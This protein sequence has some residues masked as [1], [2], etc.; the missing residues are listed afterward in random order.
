MSKDTSTKVG[1]VVLG[2]VGMTYYLHTKDIDQ[3]RAECRVKFSEEQ[4]Q[5]VITN[6]KRSTN[7]M[8]AMPILGE[9]IFGPSSEQ[10]EQIQNRIA[11][12]CLT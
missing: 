8:S 7:F 2:I 11:K 10:Q 3:A 12:R 5:C 6:I 4:C 1:A 9:A